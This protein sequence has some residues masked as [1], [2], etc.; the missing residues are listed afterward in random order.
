MTTARYLVRDVAEAIQF[1]TET[2]GFEVR[3]RFEL[4]P[5]ALT[6][7]CQFSNRADHPQPVGLGWHPYFPKRAQ[8]HL[9]IAVATRWDSD[10]TQLPVR[11]AQAA[12]R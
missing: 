4:E 8:S 6:V 5:G 12:I 11:Q 10:A 9:D 1:Y 2:L 7:H 3:Q